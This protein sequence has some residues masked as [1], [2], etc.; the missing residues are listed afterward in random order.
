[1]ICE[2]FPF[3]ANRGSARVKYLSCVVSQV[4]VGVFL[5]LIGLSIYVCILWV[6]VSLCVFFPLG[7]AGPPHVMLLSVRSCR[8]SVE[9]EKET[10]KSYEKYMII[11]PATLSTKVL[12]GKE[13]L[14]P[15]LCCCS[16]LRAPKLRLCEMCRTAT[17]LQCF[18]L[19]CLFK[20]SFLHMDSQ[21]CVFKNHLKTK[22]KSKGKQRDS[23]T[24]CMHVDVLSGSLFFSGLSVCVRAATGNYLENWA[25]WLFL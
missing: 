23:K 7:S 19:S 21:H 3:I 14:F 16:C 2:L 11:M 8:P 24:K 6:C 20:H 12:I 17:L 13:A 4:C 10:E 9:T 18:N 22:T 25:H 1:M 15:C 5:C